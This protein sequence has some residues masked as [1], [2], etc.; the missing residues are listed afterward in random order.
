MQEFNSV[1]SSMNHTGAKNS[2][3]LVTFS[4]LSERGSDWLHAISKIALAN[5]QTLQA[6]LLVLLVVLYF[7]MKIK[8]LAIEYTFLASVVLVVL[9]G[10]YGYALGILPI[11]II[12][13]LA[14]YDDFKH[15]MKFS[16][17]FGVFFSLNLLLVSLIPWTILFLEIQKIRVIRGT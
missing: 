17:L 3:L 14:S 4:I 13:I 7:S 2:S 10:Q 5:F 11:A 16:G 15:N 6:L 8:N 12:L 9:A 1:G